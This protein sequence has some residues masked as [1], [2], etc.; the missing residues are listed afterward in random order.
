MHIVLC[1]LFL[2][3]IVT[4][5]APFNSNKLSREKDSK[6]NLYVIIYER[7]RK[8]VSEKQ[9][10]RKTPAKHHCMSET[11]A[12]SINPHAAEKGDNCKRMRRINQGEN[13]LQIFPCE[14]ETQFFL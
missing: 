3:A 9:K 8:N 11:R 1:I 2:Y 13:K 4:W 6:Q 14:K 7:E 5:E 12:C 10:E